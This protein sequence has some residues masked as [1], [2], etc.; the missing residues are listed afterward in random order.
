MKDSRT[1][2]PT[3]A[4]TGV[5][6]AGLAAAV[7]TGTASAASAASAAPSAQSA[8]PAASA[9]SAASASQASKCA[10]THGTY[11]GRLVTQLKL[12]AWHHSKR[13]RKHAPK[14]GFVQVWRSSACKT[15]WVKTVKTKKYT[16][17]AVETFA[18]IGRPGGHQPLGWGERDTKGSVSTPA[19]RIGKAHVFEIWGGYLPNSRIEFQRDAKIRL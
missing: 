16:H 4:V 19:V 7:L 3:L 2:I 10:R 15:V 6:T 12:Y 11:H 5:L 9:A 1:P 8:A 13:I 18:G 14:G 17:E